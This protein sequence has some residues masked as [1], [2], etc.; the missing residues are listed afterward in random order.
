MKS[1][2]KVQELKYKA[3]GDI[4]KMPGELNA[5]AKDFEAEGYKVERGIMGTVVLKLDD[6]EVHFIPGG[7]CIKQVVFAY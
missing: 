2:K 3:I 6:G 7:S 1:M 4:L 5:V